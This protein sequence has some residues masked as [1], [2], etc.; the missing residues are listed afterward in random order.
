AAAA[1]GSPGARAVRP[2]GHGGRPQAVDR[3]RRPDSRDADDQRAVRVFQ[4]ENGRWWAEPRSSRTPVS[5]AAARS[6]SMAPGAASAAAGGGSGL[7]SG[8]GVGPPGSGSGTG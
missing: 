1:A 5:I 4:R 8:G 3:R 7:G 6:S 2:D